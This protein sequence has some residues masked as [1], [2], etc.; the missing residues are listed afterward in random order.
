MNYMFVVMYFGVYMVTLV[1]F[2]YKGGIWLDAKYETGMIPT[3]LL[4][5]SAIIFSF[6]NLFEK[7]KFF[8]KMEKRK[9]NKRNTY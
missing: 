9:K 8:E 1:W 6:I 7:I 2:A 3:V 4:I 5:L